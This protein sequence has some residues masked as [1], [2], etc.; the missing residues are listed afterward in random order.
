VPCE[1]LRA[2]ESA[3][4]RLDLEHR[5][6]G[7][8]AAANEARNLILC[9]VTR[10]AQWGPGRILI[11]CEAR[12]TRPAQWG[13]GRAASAALLAEGRPVFWRERG[14]DVM[15]MVTVPARA[16]PSN[17]KKKKTKERPGPE[18]EEEEEFIQVRIQRIL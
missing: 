18:E 13:H 9:E 10:P 11:L 2:A 4:A 16:R 7:D 15:V 14:R 1:L 5:A 3:A 17:L 8:G 6:G 12:V